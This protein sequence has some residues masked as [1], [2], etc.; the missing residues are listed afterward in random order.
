[1][2]GH[3]ILFLVVVLLAGYYAGVTWPNIPGQIKGM[4]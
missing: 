4:F 2:K 1:M 3:H